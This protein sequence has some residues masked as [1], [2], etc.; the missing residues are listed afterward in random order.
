MYSPL[1]VFP[2]LPPCLTPHLTWSSSYFTL[3]PQSRSS[4]SVEWCNSKRDSQSFVLFISD[5]NSNNSEYTPCFSNA[6][7]KEAGTQTDRLI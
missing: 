1:A 2:V 4:R 3:K 7:L 5:F 6:D